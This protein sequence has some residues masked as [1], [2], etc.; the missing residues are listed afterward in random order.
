MLTVINMP[1]VLHPV[2]RPDA[3]R[4]MAEHFDVTSSERSAAMA[5]IEQLYRDR[6]TARHG[7]ALKD[8]ADAVLSVFAQSA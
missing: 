6:A 4:W 2:R 3:D 5:A 7:A 8:F 1:P